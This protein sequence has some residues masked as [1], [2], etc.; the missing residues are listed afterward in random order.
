[1]N[2]ICRRGRNRMRSCTSRRHFG[3]CL[4][5]DQTYQ[6]N[7]CNKIDFFNVFAI[8]LISMG[9]KK[10]SRNLDHIKV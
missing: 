1:M 3:L 2:Y 4:H 8:M 7:I 6:Q 9:A 5:S 10:V